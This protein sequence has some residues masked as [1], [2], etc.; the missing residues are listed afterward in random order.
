[1]VTKAGVEYVSVRRYKKMIQ[2]SIVPV[3][4]SGPGVEVEEEAS[5]VRLGRVVS[6]PNEQSPNFLKMHVRLH[7]T[8]ESPKPGSWIGIE[9]TASDGSPR[10]ILAR[11]T[12][13]WEHNPH[14]DPQGSTVDE[15]LP[16][17][18]EYAPEGE[19]TVIYRIA[20]VEPM[21]EVRLDSEGGLGDIHEVSTLPKAGAPVFAANEELVSAALGLEAEPSLGLE[22][23]TIRGTSAGSVAA[24]LKRSV[25]QRHI[26]IVGGIGTGKSYLRGVIAEELHAQGVPQVNIDPNGELIEA[27]HQLGGVNLVPGQNGFTL[28]LSSLTPDDVI[29]SIPGMRSGTN[30]ETLIRYAHE[31]LLRE[32]TIARGEHFTVADLV[33]K[34]A[35]VAPD[36]HMEA[37][38]TLRPAQQRARS[39][40][41]VSYIGDPF[42]WE[43]CLQPGA[44][45]NIDCRGLLVSDLRLIVASIARDLQRIARRGNNIFTIFSIDEAHLVAPNDDKSVTT[46]VL[47][48]IAR[49]GRHYK[50]GLIL[51]TQSPADMDRSILKRLLTRFLF[52]IEP[53]Q[54]D[55]LRGIFADTSE[56]VIKMLPKLP[57]GTCILTGS[58]ETVRHSALINV[59]ER[60]TVHGGGTPNIWADFAARGW[61]T[62]RAVTLAAT[63]PAAEGESNGTRRESRHV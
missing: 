38:G 16:F 27:T 1:M 7:Y 8:A 52:A 50:L 13:T 11:V 17:D 6:V 35:L 55:A 31:A 20:E 28:P 62:K 48:E 19:S 42:N 21:E 45:I 53:D 39:L 41:Y 63:E 51:T 46:Q 18:T 58:Y 24:T 56:N 36:L 44:I 25:I 60:L 33:A 47:R 23:G 49:I 3:A 4:S 5:L 12:N 37:A 57:Q 32:R 40:E 14:E 43:E 29:D 59:R 2:S 15:V 30:Y 26:L 34:I 10:R 9:A 22:L 61:P 54:L